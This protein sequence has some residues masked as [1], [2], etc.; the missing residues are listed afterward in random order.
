MQ[1]LH[2]LYLHL[3]RVQKLDAL[4]SAFLC[5]AKQT[6]KE[7]IDN[8]PNSKDII[9]LLL[10]F[11]LHLEMVTRDAF[12]GQELFMN[13]LKGILEDVLNESEKT[14]R[15]I[16][17]LLAKHVDGQLRSNKNCNDEGEKFLN[18]VLSLFRHL[19]SKDVFE[20]FYKRDLAKR[21]L[22]QKSASIDFEKSFL[23][24]LKT[25]CGTGYTAKMEGM[26][27]DM[28]L[29][30]DVMASF[31]AAACTA[32]NKMNNTTTTGKMDVQILTTGYWPVYQQ[33]SNIKLP[34]DM[35]D[36]IAKFEEYYANKYQGRRIAWQ[37]SLGN[38]HVK[39]NFIKGTKELV[40]SQYQAIVL[41]LCFNNTSKQSWTIKEVMKTTGID[42][43]DEAERI[44][45]S[46]AVG[47]EGTRVLT[48]SSKKKN[49]K[50]VADDDTISYNK[51]FESRQHRIKI[52]QIQMKETQEER[53]K[54]HES[55]SRDRLYLID[56]AVV[57]IMK[58][59]KTI[60]HQTLLGEVMAQVKFPCN[61]PDVK[62]R[63]ESLIEREYMERDENSVSRY[64]YLA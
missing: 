27:K 51:N 21:L 49:R 46:L 4:R 59:R 22:L 25:E 58:A 35:C 54:T 13:S 52:T 3:R 17:E 28:D 62:K 53:N 55:V 57:R 15:L 19:S 64:N 45:L 42:N 11:K 37:H 23:S 31:G 39:A 16:A 1:D 34:T 60:D 7:I 12:S 56:A 47:K 8:T 14:G 10:K 18:D 33:M 41:I 48:K 36:Y 40:L 30:R 50:V 61:G 26:F 29:S 5:H 20:A 24:K 9:P 32:N 63:I 6:G 38:C 43:R 44:L 2:L